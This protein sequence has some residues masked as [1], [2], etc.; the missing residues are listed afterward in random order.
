MISRKH[1]LIE[2]LFCCLDLFQTYNYETILLKFALQVVESILI[3]LGHGVLHLQPD[4]E[5]E[6]QQG[7]NR[8]GTIQELGAHLQVL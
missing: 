4:P 5:Q 1:T 7:G 8:P 2:I 3:S 6:G